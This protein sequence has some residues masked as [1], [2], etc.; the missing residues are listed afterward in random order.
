[1]ISRSL[2][3]KRPH[4]YIMEEHKVSEFLSYFLT[5]YDAGYK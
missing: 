4:V 3:I 1:M 2:A 5:A